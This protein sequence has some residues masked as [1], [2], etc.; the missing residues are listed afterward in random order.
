VTY[1]TRI[2]SVKITRQILDTQDVGQD[3]PTY[4]KPS[5]P[6]PCVIS[7]KYIIETWNTFLIQHGIEEP[8]R[9]LL[10]LQP[11][12]IDQSDDASKGR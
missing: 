7:R 2:S 10:V 1:S 12:I 6:T 5:R 9:R 3:N 4:I 11:Q 8:K